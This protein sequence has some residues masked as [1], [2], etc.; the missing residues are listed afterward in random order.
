MKLSNRQKNLKTAL[1]NV[2]LP[3]IPLKINAA[4]IIQGYM[5]KVRSVDENGFPKIGHV[6]TEKEK[7]FPVNQIQ[8]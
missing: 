5:Y 2:G 8:K 1:E 4:T 7:T 6:L 3:F